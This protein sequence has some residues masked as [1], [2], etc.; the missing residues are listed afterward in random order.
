MGDHVQRKKLG[1]GT[2]NEYY[3]LKVFKCLDNTQYKIQ[4][5]GVLIK[6]KNN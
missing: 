1:S 5:L 4:Y 2:Q 6:Q 3:I